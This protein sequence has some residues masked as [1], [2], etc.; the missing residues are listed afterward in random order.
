MLLTVELEV[1]SSPEVKFSL[2]EQ[3]IVGRTFEEVSP[4][5]ENNFKITTLDNYD[6]LFGPRSGFHEPSKK[7][8]SK[9]NPTESTSSKSQ[10]IGDNSLA[11]FLAK[12]EGNR[13]EGSIDNSSEPLT[14]PIIEGKCNCQSE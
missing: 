11:D 14:S 2:S 4:Q 1:E 8:V 6:E 3:I 13:S 10:A 5:S 7:T 12:I 9:S